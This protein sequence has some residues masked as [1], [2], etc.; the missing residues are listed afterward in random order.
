M[1][2][3]EVGEKCFYEGEWETIHLVERCKVMLTRNQN[4]KKRLVNG[5]VGI[6]KRINKAS[7]TIRF[8]AFCEGPDIWSRFGLHSVIEGKRLG[9]GSPD[10]MSIDGTPIGRH[11]GNWGG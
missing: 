4:Q 2:A 6:L 8:P 1:S 5:S 11:C 7:L 9:A 3:S 10:S